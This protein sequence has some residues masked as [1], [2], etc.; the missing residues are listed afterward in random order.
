MFSKPKDVLDAT[1]THTNKRTEPLNKHVELVVKANSFA[2]QIFPQAGDLALGEG[3]IEFVSAT[4]AG[5]IQIP[6]STIDRVTVDIVGKRY[7]RAITVS[8]NGPDPLSLE[9][10]L[11][12][13]AEVIRVIAGHVSRDCIVSAPKALTSLAKRIW[14]RITAPF[15]RPS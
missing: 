10:V 9:F 1:K 13:G 12:H 5:F 3:G 6:W 2:N 7:V 8:T 15:K 4:T 11:S 14:Q